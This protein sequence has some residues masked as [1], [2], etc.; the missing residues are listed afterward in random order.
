MNDPCRVEKKQ[1][2]IEREL[3]RVRVKISTL[4]EQSSEL[5][6][7]LSPVM[8]S[9]PIKEDNLLK[10]EEAPNTPLGAELRTLNNQINT[11]SGVFLDILN[12]LEV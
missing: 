10:E 12:R 8:Q 9:S 1:Y 11:I 7:R 3:Q 2:E 6:R 4:E 5:Q